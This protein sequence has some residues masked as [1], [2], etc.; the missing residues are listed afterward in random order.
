M[1]HFR[2]QFYFTSKALIIPQSIFKFG[3]FASEDKWTEK[4]ERRDFT[5]PAAEAVGQ[6]WDDFYDGALQGLG[7]GSESYNRPN[8]VAL[9]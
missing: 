5:T 2:L 3:H 6:S 9:Y 7:I 1:H 8:T 4:E